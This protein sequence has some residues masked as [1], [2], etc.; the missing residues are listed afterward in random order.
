MHIRRKIVIPALIALGAAA[1][2]LTAAAPIAA[3]AA[4]A[5]VAQA[6]VHPD[7]FYHG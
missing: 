3:A 5:A 6:G 1:A 2:A 4:P 7:I